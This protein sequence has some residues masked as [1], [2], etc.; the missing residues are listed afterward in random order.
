MAFNLVNERLSIINWPDSTTLPQATGIFSDGDATM[1][2]GLPFTD[3]DIE[4][5]RRTVL[6][7]IP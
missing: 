6:L 7:I 2:L 5:I 1:L 3:I 4:S